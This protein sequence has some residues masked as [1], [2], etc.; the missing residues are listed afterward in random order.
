MKLSI[1]IPLYNEI[2]TIE[3]L[4]KRI[5][6]VK[7]DKEIVIVDD[8]SKDGSREWLQNLNTKNIKKVFHDKNYGKGM[9]IR[10]GIKEATGD[11]IIIQ[12]ADLEYD[13]N[14]YPELVKP[15]VEGKAEVVYGS[16]ILGNLMRNMKGKHTSAYYEYYMGGKALTILTNIL[17]NAKITD[18]PT[19]YKVFKSDVIKN[20]DLKCVRFEFCPEVTAKVR[21]KGHKIYEIPIKYNPRSLDEG[22]KIKIKDGFEA[23]WALLKYRFVN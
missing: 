1:I 15:I 6:K 10:S 14:D 23:V 2:K 9:A 7:M 11:I 16:R 5:N 17:Y 3:E 8:F 21:K 20:L 12:D 22:K 13:P 4:L 19:C 18:E